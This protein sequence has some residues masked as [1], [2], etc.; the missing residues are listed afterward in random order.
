VD[1]NYVRFDDNVY[2]IRGSYR[3]PVRP[4]YLPGRCDQYLVLAWVRNVLCDTIAPPLRLS[5]YNHTGDNHRPRGSSQGK[6]C[7]VNCRY[8]LFYT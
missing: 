6:R 7:G 3:S 5:L 4:T 2:S 8:T 1:G